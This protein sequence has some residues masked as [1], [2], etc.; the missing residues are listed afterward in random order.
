MGEDDATDARRSRHR[1]N[2][3]GR[4][5]VQ[6]KCS[7][8]LS[9]AGRGMLGASRWVIWPSA[10]RFCTSLTNPLRDMGDRLA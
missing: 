7:I 10:G 8:K 6:R 2:I 4:N 9:K 3:L 5:M 1:P